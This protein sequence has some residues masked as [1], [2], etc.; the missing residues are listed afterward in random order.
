LKTAFFSS[1][2]SCWARESAIVAFD[3]RDRF[4]CPVSIWATLGMLSLAIVIVGIGITAM[5]SSKMMA[6]AIG[7]IAVALAGPWYLLMAVYIPRWG[8]DWSPSGNPWNAV[9]HPSRQRIVFWSAHIVLL[10]VIAATF[11]RRRHARA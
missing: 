9:V 2:L 1:L 7:T 10:A 6:R 8:I 11:R 3:P 5:K 4:D